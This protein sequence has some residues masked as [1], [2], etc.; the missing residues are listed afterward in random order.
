[1]KIR[2]NIP[3]DAMKSDPISPRYQAEVDR[4]TERA[5]TAHAAAIRRLESAERRLA[6]A[7]AKVK[8]RAD[9]RRVAHLEIVV[10]M[11]RVELEGLHRLMVATRYPATARGTS[12]FRP[13][14][15]PGGAL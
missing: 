12:S 15:K 9:E 11:R 6:K 10:E 7:R 2:H 8:K 1:M 3:I 4:C 5:E 13:V 14:P